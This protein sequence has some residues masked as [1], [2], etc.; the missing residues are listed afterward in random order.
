MRNGLAIEKTDPFSALASK[1]GVPENRERLFW[2]AQ[3]IAPTGAKNFYWL[4]FVAFNLQGSQL[5]LE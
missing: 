2:R 1:K 4:F 5:I 3:T